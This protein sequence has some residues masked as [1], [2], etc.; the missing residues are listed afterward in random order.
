VR[1]TYSKTSC[2]G[3]HYSGGLHLIHPWQLQN[4]MMT[5]GLGHTVDAFIMMGVVKH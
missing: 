1:F 5:V 3:V 4:R 2:L